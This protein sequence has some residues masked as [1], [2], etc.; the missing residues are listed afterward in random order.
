M[1]SLKE[2]IAEACERIAENQR[3]VYDKGVKDGKA[4]VRLSVFYCSDFW[5]GGEP[6][7]FRHGMTWREFV[8]SKCNFNGSFNIENEHPHF[9]GGLILDVK[10]D[11]VIVDDGMY[12]A[13]SGRAALLYNG[14]EI[15]IQFV[16]DTLWGD[17]LESEL[18]DIG[19]YA[20]DEG[21]VRMPTGEY[22]L[23]DDD[24][25]GTYETKITVDM[26]TNYYE[27]IAH[28]YE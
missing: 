23:C 7:V 25:N 11:D 13:A 5:D 19:L 26:S 9:N 6:Y 12:F 10:T 28:M 18:N 4:S 15:Q 20:D 3:R 22:I 17:W 24:W 2:Q 21:Y 1:D 8:D 16:Y 27:Y 14:T